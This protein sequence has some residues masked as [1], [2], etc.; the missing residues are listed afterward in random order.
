MRWMKDDLLAYFEDEQQRREPFGADSV[1]EEAGFVCV[2]VASIGSVHSLRLPP[3]L[4]LH[5]TKKR[6]T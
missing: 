1:E 5:E 6:A 4:S 2:V 3:L